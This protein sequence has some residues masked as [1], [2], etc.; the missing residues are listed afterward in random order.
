MYL[1]CIVL[2]HGRLPVLKF[3]EKVLCPA[4]GSEHLQQQLQLAVDWALWVCMVLCTNNP[5]ETPA[6][7]IAACILA[8]HHP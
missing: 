4:Q 7:C 1:D 6:L 5:C 3:A 2:R 8:G